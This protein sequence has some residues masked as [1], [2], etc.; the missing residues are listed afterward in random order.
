MGADLISLDTTNH[1]RGLYGGE[2]ISISQW[3][4]T[5]FL[6]MDRLR[7]ERSVVVDDPFSHRFLRDR[8]RAVA[9]ENRARFVILYLDTSPE[10]IT[11]RRQENYRQPSRHHIGEEVFTAHAAEFQHPT[12]DEEPLIQLRDKE[13]LERWLFD[14]KL[15]Q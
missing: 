13:D 12:S 6:A 11:L 4:E 15:R 9:E 2:G 7:A 10:T 5:S 1:E 14:E 3:E 8:C